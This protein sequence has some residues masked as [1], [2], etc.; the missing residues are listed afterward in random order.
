MLSSN[1]FE[2]LRKNQPVTLSEL[3]QKNLEVRS[4]NPDEQVRLWIELE[5]FFS[6][7]T[8]EMEKK[9]W[10][11]YFRWYVELSW[12]TLSV[13]EPKYISDTLFARLVPL[14]ILLEID[15]WKEFIRYLDFHYFAPGEMVVFY[16]NVKKNFL[17]STAHVGTWQGK[18]L[19]VADLVR[20]IT[21]VNQ[22][23]KESSL[24]FAEVLAKVHE[25]YFPENPEADEY[26]ERYV[27]ISAQEAAVRFVDL[28]NFF[29]GVDG[30]L[31]EATVEGLLHGEKLE[32]IMAA[33]AEEEKNLQ[34]ATAPKPVVSKKIENKVPVENKVP[35]TKQERPSNGEIKKMVEQMFP[36]NKA[37]QDSDYD[38]I[39]AMLNT[40]SDR[41]QDQS[42]QDLY[43]YNEKEGSFQWNEK[44][45]NDRT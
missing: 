17:K 40:L 32:Q 9:Y 10:W 28:V 34:V 44:L 42:I 1:F 5:I 23:K 22:E 19:S 20:E 33:N 15:V 37:K 21:I 35:E 6:K 7:A 41:Y 27:T 12:S 38:K 25:M 26:L 29:L 14:A 4:L 31:I 45:L 8:P 43:F 36:P 24:R 2:Q 13:R 16:E 11:S 18:D 30:S 39:V 3:D